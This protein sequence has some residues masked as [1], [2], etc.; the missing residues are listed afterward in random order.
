MSKPALYPETTPS[1]IAVD[2]RTFERVIPESKRS[3]G[4]TRKEIKIR[5]GFTPQED[6][7]RF[8][9]TKQQEMDA[10]ALPKGHIVGWVA[11][12]S[13]TNNTTGKPSG[14]MSKSQKK[15][16]KRKEKKKA[17]IAKKIQENWEDSDED[18][19]KPASE[20]KATTESSNRTDSATDE[21]AEKLG[22]LEVNN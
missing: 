10:R 19:I 14:T 6:V 15:N 17:D 22:K 11:P 18:E 9:G 1:G 5:P 2:P 4:S 3:D 20:P 7:R 8:R 21:V 16:E 13:A 12:P